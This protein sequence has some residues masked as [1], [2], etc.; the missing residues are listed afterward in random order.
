MKRKSIK[1]GLGFILFLIGIISTSCSSLSTATSGSYISNKNIHNSKTPKIEELRP[2]D[3]PWHGN[4]VIK[5]EDHYKSY[6]PDYALSENKKLEK[7][8]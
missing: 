2:I 4:F 6:G 8:Y 7:A 1:S 5:N 3:C